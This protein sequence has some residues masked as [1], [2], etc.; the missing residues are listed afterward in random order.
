MFSN[1]AFFTAINLGSY[2]HP[3]TVITFF[4]K[5][6]LRN[7]HGTNVSKSQF[8]SRTLLAGFAV[9][10]A[11]AKQ[12]YGVYVKILLAIRNI[13]LIQVYF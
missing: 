5:K 1:S 11:R 3:H 10:A 7:I 12:I 6:K 4:D 9:A 13:F 2:S 8:Q